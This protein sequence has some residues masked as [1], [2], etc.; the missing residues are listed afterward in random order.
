MGSARTRLALLSLALL[1][2][3]HCSTVMMTNFTM[4]RKGPK[5]NPAVAVL[6]TEIIKAALACLLQTL[7]ARNTLKCKAVFS[8]S[9]IALIAPPAAMYTAQNYLIY[10]A[11]SHLELVTFQILYQSKLLLTA[12]FS[13]AFL[14]H[15]IR[16]IQW[17]A[18]FFLTVGV[19]IV[20]LSSVETDTNY[21]A[22]WREGNRLGQGTVL[23]AAA[24]SSA[25]GVYFEGVVKS[26]NGETYS[27]WM[28]NIH[29]CMSTIP[30]AALGVVFDRHRIVAAGGLL[31]GFD[32]FAV[33]VVLLNASG[34]LIVATVILY[35]DNM[36][37]NFST[38]C[39]VVLGSVF[40]MVVFDFRPS[41]SFGVGAAFVMISTIVYSGSYFDRLSQSDEEAKHTDLAEED[42]LID[43]F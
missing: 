10:L 28:R 35:G 19:I 5:Q 16:C 15:E 21:V 17:I 8:I 32:V 22:A 24:L 39:S 13:V 4:R 23:V 34:G 7:L 30:L 14:G 12:I 40:S 36:L 42:P 20:E 1:L 27:L 25:A 26:P 6:A 29:L 43:E 41:V 38:A 11:L 31:Y 2:L 33:M 9:Q 18:L 3:E 37:K